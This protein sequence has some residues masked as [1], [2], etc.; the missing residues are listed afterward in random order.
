MLCLDLEW[1]TF[2]KTIIS[3]QNYFLGFQFVQSKAKN[4]LLCSH[5]GEGKY[6]PDSQ[7]FPLLLQGKTGKKRYEDINTN[8]WDL[9]RKY[10]EKK[11]RKKKGYLKLMYSYSASWSVCYRRS[12]EVHVVRKSTHAWTLQSALTFFFL[13]GKRKTMLSLLKKEATKTR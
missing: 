4:H 5:V 13:I 12:F 6:I 2:C 10:E 8:S 11:K 9:L 7:L 1:N 3:I